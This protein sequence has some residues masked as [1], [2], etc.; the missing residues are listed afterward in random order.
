MAALFPQTS[1]S[2]LQLWPFA[3]QDRNNE[4]RI[5]AKYVMAESLFRELWIF[6]LKEQDTKKNK[7]KTNTHYISK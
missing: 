7:N 6:I 3:T 4:L 2:D 5:C 1:G